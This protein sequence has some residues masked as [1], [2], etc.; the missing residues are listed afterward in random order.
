[1]PFIPC[2]F[3]FEILRGG[4]ELNSVTKQMFQGNTT[5]MMTPLCS[6]SLVMDD[7]L[8][9]SCLFQ[10]IVKKLKKKKIKRK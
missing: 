2:A 9:H 8:G 5:N 4:K 3:R 1:M 7:Y 6:L 10:V